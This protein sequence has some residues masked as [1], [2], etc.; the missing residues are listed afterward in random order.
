MTEEILRGL[1][2]HAAGNCN[3]FI[4]PYFSD[5]QCGRNLASDAAA[6]IRSLM[7]EQAANR[8]RGAYTERVDGFQI[9]DVTYLGDPPQDRPIM[10]D[11][12]KWA[13]TEPHEVMDLRT[14]KPKV[15]A[16]HCYSVARLVWNQR[17]PCFEFQSIGMRWLEANPTERVIKMITEFADRKEDELLDE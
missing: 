6:L 14:G 9:R 17:E 15:S 7:P 3:A 8:D 11:I 12:V 1:D 4:C 5:E 2:S 16:E 13:Q 10:F